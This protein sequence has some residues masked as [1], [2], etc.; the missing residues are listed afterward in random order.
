MC[1]Q[2]HRPAPW[3]LEIVQKSLPAFQARWRANKNP[4]G[5]ARH[6]AAYA[7]VYLQT[8]DKV[9][10]DFVF[11]MNDWICALQYNQL[12]PQHPLWV[13]GFMSSVDGKPVPAPPQI[14]AA[15]WPES[16]V[17]AARV[18][19]QV[20]DVPRWERYKAA[21]QRG[22]QFLTTL[23]YTEANS[24]HFADWYRPMILGAFHAS[25]TDGNIRLEYTQQA[26][27]AMLGYLTH[28]VGLAD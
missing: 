11:E 28:K 2:Q 12:D 3:K 13:G 14:V 21:V 23:Q 10:A 9:Y 27:S 16:L 8:K 20:G 5:I 6:T 26:V 4:A 22:L 15:A 7:E 17:D 18:A 25:H 24:Q 19:R 1:S